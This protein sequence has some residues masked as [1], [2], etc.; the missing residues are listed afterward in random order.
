MIIGCCGI[1]YLCLIKNYEI[2]YIINL[3]WIY[4]NMIREKQI[5]QIKQML[6]VVAN[7]DKSYWI[8]K[9]A[10]DQLY[11]ILL[12]IKDEYSFWEMYKA[13]LNNLNTIFDKLYRYD[14]KIILPNRKEIKKEFQKPDININ[15]S[16]IKK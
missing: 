9:N 3:L 5:N 7:L 10:L 15:L 8:D 11:I 1:I 13:I 6:D 12:N 2:I 14:N 16:A 4:L